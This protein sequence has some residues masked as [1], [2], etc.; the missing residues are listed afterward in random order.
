VITAIATPLAIAAAILGTVGA[1]IGYVV[2]SLGYLSDGIQI[3]KA[4]FSGDIQTV[5]KMFVNVLKMS[6]ESAQDLTEKLLS[7]K[8]KGSIVFQWLG[9]NVGPIFGVIKDAITSI[10]FSKFDNSTKN[11]RS[12]FTE[13][14]STI[15]KDVSQFTTYM[16]KL[17]D[18]F[19][20][21]PIKLKYQN[22]QVAGK[23]IELHAIVSKNLGDIYNANLMFNQLTYQADVDR[24]NKKIET[25]KTSLDKEY[26]TVV[27][28]LNKKRDTELQHINT[29]MSETLGVDFAHR[30][31]M[32]EKTKQYYVDQENQLKW[33]NIKI[34]EIMTI[35]GNEKRELTEKEQKTIEHIREHSEK[36][37]LGIV[38]T[39]KT[40]QARILLD[41]KNLTTANAKEEAL[42]VIAEANRTY[43]TI[44]QKEKKKRDDKIALAIT[45]RDQTSALS[46]QEADT[47]ISN[48]NKQFD[49]VVKSAR[50][51]KNATIS[52]ASERV[53]GTITAAQKEAR[54]V[55]T[56]A[57]KIKKVM[58]QVWDDLKKQIPSKIYELGGIVVSA[59]T[60]SIVKAVGN[61]LS[62]MMK[63]IA[64]F[65]SSSSSL[66]TSKIRKN[67]KG[68]R[69]FSGGLTLVGEEGPELVNLPRGSD[70]YSN[71]E[72][73]S[74]L[75]PQSSF[76]GTQTQGTTNVHVSVTGNN[77]WD[78]RAIDELGTKLV[79]KL[80]G[81]INN[82]Y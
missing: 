60:S 30:Q 80:K 26:N 12:F 49:G 19:G 68:T 31:T 58:L 57:D 35:A 77:I 10:D 15:I 5:F 51:T 7:I 23:Y 40:T 20:L 71:P 46:K 81:V 3:V 69:N 16:Y 61:L 78:N 42:Q 63:S 13:F 66:S 75:Q 32:L 6:K 18:S 39:G 53:G 54:E 17:L 55:N 41:A 37:Q 1:A 8:E 76:G 2:W 38:T 29:L 73:L 48:A 67:A 47:I 28:A 24:Y 45:A 9:Q 25:T 59:V 79:G 33:N 50:D 11:S 27:N 62:D 34:K 21:L 72:T 44:I 74:M 43:D 56:Q 65:G 70:I 82:A 64:D 4:F 52:I 14:I 22:D 36:T